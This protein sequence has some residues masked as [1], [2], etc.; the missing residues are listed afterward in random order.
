MAFLIT[1]T[2]PD[3]LFIGGKTAKYCANPGLEHFAIQK[4]ALRFLKGTL[5]HGIE[6]VW[7]ASDPPPLD[8]P[9]AIV[10]W[11]DSSFAD[12]IDTGRTTLGHLLQV[13]GA[14]VAASSKLG[15]RVDSCVNHSELRAFNGACAASTPDCV[16]DGACVSLVKAS[17]TVAW[18]RGVK[19]ALERRN[20][21]AMP[22]TPVFVDNAGVI[23]MLQGV[24]LKAANKHIFKDLAECR[25]RVNVD[26][27]VVVV[28]VDTK[29]NLANALTKQEH[30][31]ME[32]AAQLRIIAGPPS[33]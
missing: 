30:S 10:A 4:H 25:E 9:L 7:R 31:L 22:P 18:L 15:A 33:E 3:M 27:S 29:D 14:V 5:N 20:V 11:S 17:R 12:D 24:T 1:I 2:R 21:T 19:A 13:N 8:G 26:K 6:F 23:S 32:S 28:K 16:G